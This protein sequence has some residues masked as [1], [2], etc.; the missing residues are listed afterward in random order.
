MGIKQL[1]KKVVPKTRRSK[2]HQSEAKLKNIA[3]LSLKSLSENIN[4]KGLQKKTLNSKDFPIFEVSPHK[5]QWCPKEIYPKSNFVVN[6]DWDIN[7]SGPI[8]EVRKIT[9]DTVHDIFS[10]GVS[11]KETVQY[12]QMKKAVDLYQKG[13]ISRASKAGGYWCKSYEDIDEYFQ[14]LQRAYSNIKKIGYKKQCEVSIVNP[15][16]VIKSQDEIQV[17]LDRNGE[18]MLGFGGTHR[19]IITQILDLEQVYVRLVGVH[20]KFIDDLALNT[21]TNLTTAI[22]QHLQLLKVPKF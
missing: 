11:Y 12:K 13:G 9:F 8:S 19:T 2:I 18:I 4:W 14:K 17:V 3:R 6:G 15:E 16:D 1:V 10:R 5:L 20:E 22:I 21:H 7:G